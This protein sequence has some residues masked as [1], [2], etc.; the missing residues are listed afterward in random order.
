MH[1]QRGILQ[2]RQYVSNVL[3]Q[4]RCGKVQDCELRHCR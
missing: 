4:L 3:C 1:M 2:I